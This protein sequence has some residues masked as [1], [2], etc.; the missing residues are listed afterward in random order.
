M[1][2][3]QRIRNRIYALDSKYSTWRRDHPA[4][5]TTP[6]P[7]VEDLIHSSEAWRAYVEHVEDADA[8]AEPVENDEDSDYGYHAP[9]QMSK[10]DLQLW[11][12]LAASLEATIVS[13]QTGLATELAD[14]VRSPLDGDIDDITLLARATS[15]F[16][17]KKCSSGVDA[18]PQILAWPEVVQH[19]C[20]KTHDVA[21]SIVDGTPS[22]SL[23]TQLAALGPKIRVAV[24][25]MLEGACMDVDA[26]WVE[27]AKRG[28]RFFVS[29]SFQ[30]P[31][32]AEADEYKTLLSTRHDLKSL[33]RLVVG[34]SKLDVAP[35]VRMSLPATATREDGDESIVEWASCSLCAT[36][37][38][39]ERAIWA[40][41][42]RIHGVVPNGASSLRV[43]FMR[44]SSRVVVI[45][46]RAVLTAYS[47]AHPPLPRAGRAWRRGRG[48][49]RRD[50]GR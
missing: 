10:K 5:V 40:H 4:T 38:D 22:R 36:R 14:L 31:K 6:V 44:P 30:I 33:V 47:N 26:T 8:G 29:P 23:G 45:A 15:A 28:S 24:E 17:C 1:R 25:Q 42:G 27:V 18:Q 16:M 12:D 35:F 43:E 2:E 9:T 39:T 7:T 3:R 48:R 37:I 13:W 20:L 41:A 11:D 34:T 32:N 50:G 49:G 46:L 21:T 19:H